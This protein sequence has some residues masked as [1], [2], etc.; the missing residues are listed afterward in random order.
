M[1]AAKLGPADGF[2]D[3]LN[4]VEGGGVGVRRAVEEHQRGAGLAVDLEAAKDG[5]ELTRHPF[6]L[7]GEALSQVGRGQVKE[8]DRLFVKSAEM[9]AS[10]LRFPELADPFVE[11]AEADQGQGFQGA[12]LQEVQPL[13]QGGVAAIRQV[14]PLESEAVRLR[15]RGNVVQIDGRVMDRGQESSRV[16]LSVESIQG[17]SQAGESLGLAA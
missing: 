5:K 2:G 14:E 16:G 3:L 15:I 9:P 8:D 4:E 13:G 17:F 7:V 11:P 1:G 12:Q 6:H 10:F